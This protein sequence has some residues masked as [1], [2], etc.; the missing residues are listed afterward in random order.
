[1]ASLES[2]LCVYPAVRC[3]VPSMQSLSLISSR[4]G[5]LPIIR[6]PRSAFVLAFS[7]EPSETRPTQHCFTFLLPFLRKVTSGGLG[8][9]EHDMDDLGHDEDRSSMTS[10]EC[11]GQMR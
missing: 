9:D 5:I 3:L 6:Y 4:P 7:K 2:S 11:K 8:F 10:T 1:M